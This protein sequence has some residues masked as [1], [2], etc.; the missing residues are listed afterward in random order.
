MR[1]KWLRLMRI[2]PLALLFAGVAS[3]Q[4][5]GNIIGVVTDQ[6]TGKPVA[7]A[8]IVATSPALQGEQTAVT[9]QNGNYQ[10]RL[11]PPGEYKLAVQLDGYKP[12]ERSDITVRLDK[13][14][15]AMI[16]VVP[17]AVQME[18]Q[19]V[20]TGAAPAVNIGAAESGG[21]ISREFVASVPVGRTVESVSTVVPQVRSD[22]YGVGFAG[23]QSPENAYVLDGL[24]VTDPVYGTFGGNPNAQVLQP[25]L[26]TNFIQEVDVKTGG[27]MAEYGRATGGVLNMVTRSGSNEFHGSV[28]SN[29][30]PRFAFQPAGNS[31]GAAGEAVA[32]RSLPSQ[33]AYD[34]DAGFEVGGP[35]QKDR[36]WFYGGFAPIVKKLTTERYLRQ[37]AV[38]TLDNSGNCT[39]APNGMAVDSLC[40]VYDPNTGN[41]QQTRIDGTSQTVDTGRTTYQAVGKLT[42]LLDEN[43]NFTMSGFATPST[44]STY[45]MNSADS[46]RT[47]DTNDNTYDVIGRYAGKYLDKRLILEA[48]GGWHYSSSVDQPSAYQQNTSTL[49][50]R[51]DMPISGFQSYDRAAGAAASVCG[52][53]TDAATL[54]RCAVFGYMTGGLG[55]LNDQKSNR[56]AGRLSGSYLFDAAGSHNAKVGLDVERSTYTIGKDYGGHAYYYVTPSNPSS[57]QIRQYR[58][59]G[60]TA[61]HAYAYDPSQVFPGSLSNES[62]TTSTALFA[63][64]G[65]QLPQNVTINAGLRWEAQKMDNLSN[66]DSQGFSITNN[67]APRVQAIWDFTGTGRGKVA[68]SWGRFFYQMPLDMGDRAF[69]NETSLR[70]FLTPNGLCTPG[71]GMDPTKV[72]PSGNAMNTACGYLSQPATTSSRDPWIARETSGGTPAAP[73]LQATYVDQFGA[74][75]EYEILNDLSI[76]F[77]YSGRRQGNVIEDMSPDDGVTYYIAN[78]YYGKPFA[79]PEALGGGTFDPRN[80]IATDPATGRTLNVQ[81]PKPE[82]SYDGFTLFAR[83]NFSQNWQASASYTLSY[84]RGNLA[85]P[86]RPE[87]G[88]LDPGITSEY[89]LPMLMANRSGFLPGDQRHVIKLFGSYLFNFGPRFNV[90]AGAGYTGS[91]GTPVNVLGAHPDY[92]PSQAFIVPRGQ[93]GRSPY[94]GQF[95]VRGAMTYVIKPP[96]QV[97]FS[98]DVFNVFNSQTISLVDEDY[99]FDSVQPV[100]GIKC[101]ANAVGSGNPVQKLQA[102]CPQVKYMKTVDGRPVTVNQNW[103]RAAPG[104]TSYQ[105]PLSLRFGVALSF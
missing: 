69:G 21:V 73:N 80:A 17:E 50:F 12:A 43:N 74:Q 71:A 104:I 37:N 59:Y 11:L 3:A 98:L 102:A 67:W 60:T 27:F 84:L 75:A 56:L 95:D 81:F 78:P 61:T 52:T 66:P 20:R 8:L 58:G 29:F 36:L 77:E 76:G 48:V 9:D 97:A 92:G 53:A 86:Y 23:A 1:K 51:D 89:D 49:N 94:L 83:K 91:S 22:L 103:G 33:G 41:Y 26:L 88:Q 30:T 72:N 70:S 101:D 28:F 55:Y 96:Y 62:Q 65:W 4:T 57:S 15:R 19:V 68:G 16:A 2:A 79:I 6:S 24:N 82:R 64:D 46:R 90:T 10:F 31:T 105:V 99:T 7:G 93:A 40:R 39:G 25:T 44:T 5:T 100:T 13:T 45:S 47:F 35:I 54:A 32:W 38:G 87:D 18:E 85:G 14:I 42:Y 63:Q 34:L